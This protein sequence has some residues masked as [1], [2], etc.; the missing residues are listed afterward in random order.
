LQ[1]I[2][3]SVCR[4]RCETKLKGTLAVKLR[5]AI[6]ALRYALEVKQKSSHVRIGSGT[7]ELDR[8]CGGAFDNKNVLPP[9]A[10]VR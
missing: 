1:L 2:T 7:P 6:L 9:T 5:P 8:M 4:N 10:P 3:E